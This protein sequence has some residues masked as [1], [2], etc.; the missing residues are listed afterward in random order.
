MQQRRLTGAAGQA[1][2]VYQADAARQADTAYQ[3]DSAY[4]ADASYGGGSAY[5][6]DS[7]RQSGAAWQADDAREQAVAAFKRAILEGTRAFEAG[8][9]ADAFRVNLLGRM[10]D[11]YDVLLASG[12]SGELAARHVLYEFG[13]LAARMEAQGFAR[14]RSGARAGDAWPQITDEQADEYIAQ[15]D[16]YHKRCAKGAGILSACC[17]PLFAGASFSNLT[18][19][20]NLA[21][22]AVMFGLMGMFALIGYGV[23]LCATAKKPKLHEAVKRRRFTLGGRLRRR[24]ERMRETVEDAA[25]GRKGLGIALLVCCVIPLFAG[26]T[27]DTFM[28]SDGFFVTLGLSGM[29]GVIGG[30]VYELT[31]A[32]GERKPFR[33]LLKEKKR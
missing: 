3:A 25:R 28:G 19:Y 10:L 9:E 7:A 33:R 26:A 2:P 17:M 13:D 18:Y 14:V 5:R 31:L 16:A 29:F 22:A 4:R 1:D 20:T 11:R 24:L 30:G 6:A 27:L 8:P 23:Y 32:D 21:E 12:A 15:S